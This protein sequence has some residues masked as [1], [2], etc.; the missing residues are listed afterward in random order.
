[1]VGEF[2]KD[3]VYP[4]TI[5]DASVVEKAKLAAKEYFM[6]GEGRKLKAKL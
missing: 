5:E 6:N 3:V 1:M 2:E 4:A